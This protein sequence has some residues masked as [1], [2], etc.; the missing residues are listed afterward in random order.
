MQMKE[1]H[2]TAYGKKKKWYQFTR[3]EIIL[4]LVALFA[5]IIAV[6]VFK[7]SISELLNK[8]N[9]QTPGMGM[10]CGSDKGG[11]ICEPAYNEPSEQ[12]YDGFDTTIKDEDPESICLKYMSKEECDKENSYLP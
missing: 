10:N 6:I 7:Q 2:Q 8:P 1:L 4:I 3:F 11:Y 9:N 5:V 12:T